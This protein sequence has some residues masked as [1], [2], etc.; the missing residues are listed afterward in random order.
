MRVED[1][2]PLHVVVE[3]ILLK[4]ISLFAHSFHRQIPG[5]LD[6]G[7]AQ[8]VEFHKE[9]FV[10]REHSLERRQHLRVNQRD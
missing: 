6:D 8:V 3:V 7:A 1:I 2:E 4:V 9:M 5:L 10:V